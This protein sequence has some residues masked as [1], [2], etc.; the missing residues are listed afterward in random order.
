[1]RREYHVSRSFRGNR[2]PLF[3]GDSVAQQQLSCVLVLEFE[4]FALAPNS[5]R[6]LEA[7]QDV[8]HQPIPCSLF[9]RRRNSIVYFFEE[10]EEAQ[11][12]HFVDAAGASVSRGA[13]PCQARPAGRIDAAP[14]CRYH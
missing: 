13:A 9:R 8:Q 7:E 2:L 1:M 4:G 12:Q 10:K 6:C 5:F 3:P 11:V 14:Q